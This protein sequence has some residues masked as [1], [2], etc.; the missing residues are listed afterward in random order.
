MNDFEPGQRVERF[1]F[2]KC[3]GVVARYFKTAPE[4]L[5]EVIVKWDDGSEDCYREY[6]L[7]ASDVPMPTTKTAAPIRRGE[8]VMRANGVRG[9]VRRVDLKVYADGVRGLVVEFDDGG[10][11]MVPEDDRISREVSA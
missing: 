8:R 9:V 10:S 7:L 3:V 6:E 11:L 4:G 5:G 1:H 2:R